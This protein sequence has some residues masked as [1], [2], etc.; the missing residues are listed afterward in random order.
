MTIRKRFRVRLTSD[1]DR[2]RHG[3]RR[4]AVV[5]LEDLEHAKSAARRFIVK[6]P[7]MATP[8]TRII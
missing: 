6:S 7:A 3:R 1:R 4:F 2:L 8:P 5:V